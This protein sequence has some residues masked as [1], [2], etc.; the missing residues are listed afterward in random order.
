MLG[1][2]VLFAVRLVLITPMLRVVALVGHKLIVIPLI[3]HVLEAHTAA[4]FPR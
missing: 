4:V 1:E 3:L 2:K